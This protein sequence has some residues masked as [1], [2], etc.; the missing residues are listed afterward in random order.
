VREMV[1]PGIRICAST[2]VLAVLAPARLLKTLTMLGSRVMLIHC[3]R[4]SS[5]KKLRTLNGKEERMA[6]FRVLAPLNMRTRGFASC[7][8][9]DLLTADS[10]IVSL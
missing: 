4:Y 9:H 2:R 10:G 7:H 5:A 8:M 6:A 3:G 1:L